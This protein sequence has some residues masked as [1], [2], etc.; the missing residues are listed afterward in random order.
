MKRLRQEEGRL[1]IRGKDQFNC[2]PIGIITWSGEYEKS[3]VT[4]QLAPLRHIGY[5]GKRYCLATRQVGPA[6]RVYLLNHVV[7]NSC[8]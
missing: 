7:K 1:A 4:D 2:V 5:L 8:F 6:S 3:T